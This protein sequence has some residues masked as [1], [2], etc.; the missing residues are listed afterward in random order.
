MKE[1]EKCFVI[2]PFGQTTDIH[3]EEFWTNHF[4]HLLKPLIQDKTKIIVERSKAIRIEI[5][6][7]IIKNLIFSQIV[8]ADITDLNANVMWEL[9]VRQS[10][11]N[12]TIVI[13]EEGTEIPFDISV[14]GILVYPVQSDSDFTRKSVS[15]QIDL[16][17]AIQDCIT[18]PGKADSHVLETISGRASIYEIIRKEDNL[19]RIDAFLLEFEYNISKMKTIM[20]LIEDNKKDENETTAAFRLKIEACNYLLTNRYLDEKSE[21]YELI[22]KYHTDIEIINSELNEWSTYYDVATHYFEKY[23]PS[24][25]KI[26]DEVL[27]AMKA[28]K[29]KVE[30]LI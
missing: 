25:I 3:T 28:S 27:L 21:F 20:R 22:H 1:H 30:N 18:N 29:I 15:F 8:I 2:M 16:L 5:L 9:G 11:S 12:R 24:M 19:R 7:D 4:N 6:Q 17:L 14:N 10:F 23:M 26:T 13:A